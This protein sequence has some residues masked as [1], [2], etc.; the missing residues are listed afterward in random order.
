MLIQLSVFMKKYGGWRQS[1]TQSKCRHWIECTLNF[2]SVRGW[3]DLKSRAE[4]D[5][6]KKSP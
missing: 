1:S 3:V 6:K 5:D 2:T 4:R